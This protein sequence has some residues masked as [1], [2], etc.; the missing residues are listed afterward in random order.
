MPYKSN[1]RTYIYIYVLMYLCVYMTK[2]NLNL[3]SSLDIR[4]KA[5]LSRPERGWMRHGDITKFMNDAI[6][7]Y[8]NMKESKEVLLTVPI[9]DAQEVYDTLCDIPFLEPSFFDTEPPHERSPA[10][11]SLIKQLANLYNDEE[12]I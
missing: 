4:M 5:Y 11:E 7:F 1:G 3:K 10:I 2:K 12:D 6:E 8:L 9:T